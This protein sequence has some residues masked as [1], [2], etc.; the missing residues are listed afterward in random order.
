MILDMETHQ[1]PPWSCPTKFS[2]LFSF[3][4]TSTGS[5]ITQTLS[6]HMIPSTSLLYQNQFW[7]RPSHI[8]KFSCCCLRPY[9]QHYLCM[10]GQAKELPGAVLCIETKAAALAITKTNVLSTCLGTDY[11]VHVWTQRISGL[12]FFFFF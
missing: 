7:C 10:K 12:F 6:Q 9:W 11:C 3:S 8:C 4:Q 1:N 5:Q 2:N